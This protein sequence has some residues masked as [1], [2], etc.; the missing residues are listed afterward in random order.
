MKAS[1]MTQDGSRKPD[2]RSNQEKM[3]PIKKRARFSCSDDSGKASQSRNPDA[4][5]DDLKTMI[6]QKTSSTRLIYV[7]KLITCECVCFCLCSVCF[8]L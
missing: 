8:V 1:N 2:H 7:F 5:R 4:N 3:L 6:D